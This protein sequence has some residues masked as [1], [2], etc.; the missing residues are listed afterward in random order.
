MD[1]W[2]AEYQVST[3][4]ASFGGVT[5]LPVY[6]QLLYLGLRRQ[7]SPHLIPNKGRNK[8][9]NVSWLISNMGSH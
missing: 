1:K 8:S 5:V 9:S 7:R 4:S 3:G 6:A 2:L